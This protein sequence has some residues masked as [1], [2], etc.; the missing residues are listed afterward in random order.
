MK[1]R[2]P[3]VNQE[4]TD[5]CLE[6][7]RVITDLNERARKHPKTFSIR[8]LRDWIIKLES[9]IRFLP[10]AAEKYMDVAKVIK[11]LYVELHKM[12]HGSKKVHIIKETKVDINKLVEQAEQAEKELVDEDGKILATIKKER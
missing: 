2:C 5:I 6:M 8:G 3:F 1:E 7:A 4:S 12:E 9:E 10:R 11:E